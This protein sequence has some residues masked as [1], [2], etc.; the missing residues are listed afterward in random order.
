M[1][2]QPRTHMRRHKAQ[3]MCDVWYKKV[4]MWLLGATENEHRRRRAME[5]RKSVRQKILAFIGCGIEWEEKGKSL[6][7]QIAIRFVRL[8]SIELWML[9]ILIW[10]FYISIYLS[11]SA[12]TQIYRDGSWWAERA[13][14]VSQSNHLSASAENRA[15]YF[16]QQSGEWGFS[17]EIFKIFYFCCRRPLPS[18]FKR[19]AP[20]YL[21]P[22]PKEILILWWEK[23]EIFVRLG[24]EDNEIFFFSK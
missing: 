18:L 2:I 5:G 14:K 8:A 4:M 22:F 20:V 21:I 15:R 19:K 1:D 7:A 9:G 16:S 6:K 24:G 12:E 13:G 10:Y 17:G 11:I 3:W 23:W